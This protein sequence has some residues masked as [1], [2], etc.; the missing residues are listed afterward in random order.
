M[1]HKGRPSSV[2]KN[3]D[4]QRE[5]ATKYS[6]SKS[7]TS[8]NLSS[9]VSIYDRWICLCFLNVLHSLFYIYEYLV[10]GITLLLLFV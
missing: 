4:I 2:S 3:I 9:F 8:F 5:S 6:T 7:F 10:S 1:T